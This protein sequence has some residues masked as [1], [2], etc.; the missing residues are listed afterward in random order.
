MTIIPDTISTDT[1]AIA[2]RHIN[3]GIGF[4]DAA[5]NFR[6]ELLLAV[7]VRY[8]GNQVK[9]SESM[10]IHRNTLARMMAALGIRVNTRCLDI[11]GRR[12][13]SIE[14]IRTPSD[15]RVE[16]R[17]E[18]LWMKPRRLTSSSA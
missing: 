13:R 9:A 12:R 7:L 14:W 15:Y 17:A 16:K 11:E 4:E 8:G 10:G 1:R 2:Q 6:R 3:L 5:E 18:I